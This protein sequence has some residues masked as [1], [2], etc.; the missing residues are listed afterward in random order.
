MAELPF[1]GR[2]PVFIGDDATDELGFRCE[3]DRGTS[4]KV[5]RGRTSAKWRLKD[6]ITGEWLRTGQC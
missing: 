3:Q 4:I 2:I 6:G 1:V 5:G